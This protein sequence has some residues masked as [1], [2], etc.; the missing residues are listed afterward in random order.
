MKGESKDISFI[1]LIEVYTGLLRFKLASILIKTN[2]EA[3][4]T[5]K[6]NKTS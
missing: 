3:K 4:Y 1:S 6:V 5:R 2:N